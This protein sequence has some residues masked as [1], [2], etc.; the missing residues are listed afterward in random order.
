MSSARS[1][2]RP[3][4]NTGSRLISTCAMGRSSPSPWGR[5][6]PRSVRRMQPNE[7]GTVDQACARLRDLLVQ[8]SGLGRREFLQAI[9]KAAAGSALLGPLA[10]LMSDAVEAQERAVTYFTYG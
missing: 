5:A 2:S 4:A 8:T 3:S 1:C 7:P 6:Q 9:A 10:A